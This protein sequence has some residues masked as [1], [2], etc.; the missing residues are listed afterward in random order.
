VQGTPTAEEMGFCDVV[1]VEEIGS[2][3]VT[4]FRQEGEDSGIST[5]VIRAA[6]QN[7]LDDVERSIGTSQQR[8]NLFFFFFFR[9]RSR[10]SLSFL[11]F[12]LER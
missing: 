8:E 10:F 5:I 9:F 3:K 12:L 11:S 7:V 6:T 4:I 1:T 2:T